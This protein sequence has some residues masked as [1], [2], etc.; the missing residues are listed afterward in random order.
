M[1]HGPALCEP[2]Y[3]LCTELRGQAK[4]AWRPGLLR[5][6]SLTGWGAAWAKRP[7][8]GLGAPGVGER[9]ARDPREVLAQGLSEPGWA[10][11]S[12]ISDC[13]GEV[14]RKHPFLW[15]AL[16]LSVWSYFVVLNISSLSDHLPFGLLST[17][18]RQTPLVLKGSEADSPVKS[19]F[20]V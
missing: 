14:W 6:G 4:G 8:V 18:I 3:L 1:I 7:G 12:S 15:Q 16:L 20:P 13:L 19:P 5:A 2:P 10:A 11:A 9:E 17:L